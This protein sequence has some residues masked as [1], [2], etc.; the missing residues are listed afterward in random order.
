MDWP[1]LPDGTVDW[2]TVFQA[3][4]TGLI[5]LIE[6]AATSEK[7][8]DCFAYLITV[9]FSRDDDEEIR[10]SYFEILKETF[11]GP[12]GESALRAQKTKIRM[13]MNRLMNDRIKLAREYA[14][15][16]AKRA[17]EGEG[18]ENRRLDERQE[19]TELSGAA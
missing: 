3:P 6:Q 15:A 1:K 5:A 18:D 13:V 9:L 7:L 19:E 16:K 2:M 17:E 12:G 10:Q 14:L 4:Q 8:R 11:Q